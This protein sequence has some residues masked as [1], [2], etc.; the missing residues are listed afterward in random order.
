MIDVCSSMKTT[1]VISNKTRS[2]GL[3]RSGLPSVL[4]SLLSGDKH[5]P[6]R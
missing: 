4:Y 3:P 6:S 2:G 5:V 1:A